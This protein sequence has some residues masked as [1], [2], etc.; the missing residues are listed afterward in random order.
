MAPAALPTLECAVETRAA[1]LNR[2]H[3][4][5]ETARKL[6]FS[7]GL[8]ISVLALYIVLRDVHWAE[9]GDALRQA[10]YLLIALGLGALLLTLSLRALRWQLLLQSPPALSRRQIFGALNVAYFINNIFPFQMGDLGR[11][12]LASELGGIST[13]RSLSTIVVERV[14]D[15]LVLLAFLL[16][17]APFVDIPDRA[18]TPAMLLA[19]AF[20]TLAVVLTVAAVKREPAL[21]LAERLLRLAPARSRPKLQQMVESGLDGFE[22]F[23]RPRLAAGVVAFSVVC[24]L[25]MASVLYCG[26]LAFGLGLGFEAA[27]MVVVATTFGFFVPASPGAFGVYHA[28]AIETLT[29]VFGIDRNLAVSYALT[30]HMLIYLPPIFIGTAFLWLERGLW[31]RMTVFEKL[32]ALRGKAAEVEAEMLGVERSSS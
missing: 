27:V 21:R 4:G 26:M 16:L 9:V 19:L 12:Y 11:A 22:V 6:Q 14:V 3:P 25:S 17:L 32:E 31:R 2:R 1:L 10:D 29:R 30:I 13:T 7:F 20:S 15:V 18:E 24:W 23:R 8:L 28:I 5:N